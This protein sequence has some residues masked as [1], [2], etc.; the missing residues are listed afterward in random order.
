MVGKGSD[1]T[2]ATQEALAGD[3]SSSSSSSSTPEP[4]IS[5]GKGSDH[6]QFPDI[7]NEHASEPTPTVEPAPTANTYVNSTAPLY[8]SSASPISSWGNVYK[9]P[10]D[11][12]VGKQIYILPK[13]DYVDACY[14]WAVPNG[15]VIIPGSP[16]YRL[17]SEKTILNSAF[18]FEDGD[19]LEDFGVLA[20]DSCSDWK[21]YV[22]GR[23]NGNWQ[24]IQKQILQSAVPIAP[25]PSSSATSPTWDWRKVTEL[26]LQIIPRKKD[27]SIALP[28]PVMENNFAFKEIWKTYLRS[29]VPSLNLR[30]VEERLPIQYVFTTAASIRSAVSAFFSGADA[31][32]I[33]EECQQAAASGNWLGDNGAS[34]VQTVAPADQL[35]SYTFESTALFEGTVLDASTIKLEV[36]IINCVSTN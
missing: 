31:E 27:G 34:L 21:K 12:P 4:P 22:E 17:P 30:G 18:G 8:P 14:V 5:L 11:M 9:T 16:L 2:S 7:K 13:K 6:R 26:N 29:L 3:S 32:T 1:F 28:E 33:K 23:S 20:V 15:E 35:G 36:A 25:A 24:E 19:E 10:G